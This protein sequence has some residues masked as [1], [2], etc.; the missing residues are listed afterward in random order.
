MLVRAWL[1]MRDLADGPSFFIP[2][3][4]SAMALFLVVSL[5]WRKV[6][7]NLWPHR[8]GWLLRTQFN[9]HVFIS[10]STSRLC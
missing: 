7:C 4:F 5:F 9:L 1:S 2:K 8:S 3:G 6:T 10:I